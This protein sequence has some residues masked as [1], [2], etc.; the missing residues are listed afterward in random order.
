MLPSRDRKA[1]DDFIAMLAE[2]GQ[3][4]II[5]AVTLAIQERRPSLA[6][7]ISK[8]LG[9]DHGLPNNSALERAFKAMEFLIVKPRSVELWDELDRN[10]ASWRQ[11]RRAAKAK[12]RMR[13]IKDPRGRR[14]W[15]RR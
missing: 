3:G 9:T 8:L 10:W 14:P 13:P 4:K 1:E 12:Q 5:E 15:P 2:S 11:S 7:R 6:A